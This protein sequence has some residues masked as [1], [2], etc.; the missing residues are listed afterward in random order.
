MARLVPDDHLRVR[1]V[2]LVADD[3]AVEILNEVFPPAA[4][5]KKKAEDGKQVMVPNL[6]NSLAKSFF[7]SKEW[8]PVNVSSDPKLS[9]LNPSSAPSMPYTGS[10][11][12]T[13]FHTLRTQY[14][15][16]Q[17]HHEEL[18]QCCGGEMEFSHK[19]DVVLRYMHVLYSSLP[20]LPCM[21]DLRLHLSALP[22]S[23]GLKTRPETISSVVDLSHSSAE[24][25]VRSVERASY[26]RDLAM[27]E[28][29][30]ASTEFIRVQVRQREVEFLQSQLKTASLSD[31]TRR[32]MENKLQAL[33][34]ALLTPPL[35]ERIA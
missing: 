23:P 22:S 1:A 13:L 19:D 27:E 6:W 7:N 26:R 9:H 24:G 10:Q 16:A 3:M 5:G 35:N 31:S 4:V 32:A 34:D 17:H 2:H 12:R 29:Y 28:Y 21:R 15:L 20:P 18:V 25:E 8:R 14:S 30:K 33:L 11:L